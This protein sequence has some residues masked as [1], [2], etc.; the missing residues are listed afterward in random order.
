MASP[1]ILATLAFLASCTA[2]GPTV[3]VSPGPDKSQAEFAG[4]RTVCGRA[5][6]QQLQPVATRL[7]VSATSP[8][9]AAANNRWIQEAYNASYARCMASRGD[10]VPPSLAA[11]AAPRAV[12]P[13]L[14]AGLA[15]GSSTSG[16]LAAGWQLLGLSYHGAN[17][18]PRDAN[19]ALWPREIADPPAGHGGALAVYSVVLAD[20][21][22][23]V[24]VSIASQGPDKCDGGPNDVNATRDY[25]VCPGKLAILAGDRLVATRSVGALCA[26]AINAGGVREGAPDWKDPARWGTRVRYDKTEG[27]VELMTMQGGRIERACSKTIKLRS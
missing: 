12:A 17:G 27:T 6:D 4:D 11:N 13:S 22:R 7:S 9:Q 16:H 1:A 21:P 8:Q 18:Q 5:T 15:E 10:V 3:L 23:S 26:E 24:M 14:S 19:D 2:I 20:G 25:A